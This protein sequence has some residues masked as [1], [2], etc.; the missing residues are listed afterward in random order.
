MK[1]LPQQMYEGWYV[2]NKTIATTIHYVEA[3]LIEERDIHGSTTMYKFRYEAVNKQLN[4]TQTFFQSMCPN[5]K[6]LKL[7]NYYEDAKKFLTK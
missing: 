3:F 7:F 1:N 2:F 5:M 6:E 4:F